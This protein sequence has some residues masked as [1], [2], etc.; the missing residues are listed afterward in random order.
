[1]EDPLK[2][3]KM[4]ASTSQTLGSTPQAVDRLLVPI[5]SQIQKEILSLAKTHIERDRIK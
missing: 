3:N 5:S 2:N 1:M 4:E